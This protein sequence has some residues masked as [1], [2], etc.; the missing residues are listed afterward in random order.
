MI[1]LIINTIWLSFPDQ[2]LQ[3]MGSQFPSNIIQRA[4]SAGV[5]PGFSKSCLFKIHKKSKVRRRKI[6]SS[7][8][9]GEEL[10]FSL[11]IALK[12]AYLGSLEN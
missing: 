3:K 11:V 9:A 7:W 5:A 10:F 8:A 6:V 1:S 12:H 2:Y 4:G